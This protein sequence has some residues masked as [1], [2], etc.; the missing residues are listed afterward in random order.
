MNQPPHYE[1][2]LDLALE[3]VNAE[4][5]TLEWQA[6]NQ[7]NLI[8]QTHE[9]SDLDHPFQWETLGDYT[10]DPEKA[11]P[12]YFKALNL[13]SLKGFT[14]YISSINLAISEQYKELSNF[15]KAWEYANLAQESAVK[16]SNLSLKQEIS[17]MLIELS[18][19]T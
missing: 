3:I 4:D 19:S 15:D 11:L 7:L 10:R 14:D 13:A 2:V 6:Y 18:K 9:N 8:C 5:K 17:E 1:K 16:L 12:I